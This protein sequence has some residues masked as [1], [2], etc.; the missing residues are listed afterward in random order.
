MASFRPIILFKQT[1]ARCSFSCLNNQTLSDFLNPSLAMF[2][3]Y[4]YIMAK[5]QPECSYD[6]RGSNNELYQG[7]LKMVISLSNL[8]PVK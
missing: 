1:D 8:K 7:S 3:R 5:S 6:Q 2:L 4:F